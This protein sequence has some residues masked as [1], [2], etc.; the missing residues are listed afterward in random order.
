MGLEATCNV[1][2]GKQESEGKARLESD[3]LYFRGEFRLKIPFSEMRSVAASN[4]TL[5]LRTAEGAASFELGP[6][7]AKWA[8]MIRN[9]KSV[10]DKL[11]VKSG[12][13]VALLGIEDPDF[14]RQVSARGASPAVGRL[15][16]DHDLV[17]FGVAKVGDLGRLTAIRKAIR[18]EGGIW[19]VWP[20]GRPEL[21]EDHIRS[22]AI[23]QGLTDVK[24][25]AFS[26]THS[27]LKLVIPLSR[28]PKP[29]RR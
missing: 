16:K 23:R 27:A 26:A 8:D 19:A 20:K 2:W 24:V 12:Q 29:R 21:K 13:K 18:P 3:H 28:R 9:P 1:R 15:G 6:A 4:G 14:E 7:A 22:A 10:I 11:G 17:F 25:V 5:T